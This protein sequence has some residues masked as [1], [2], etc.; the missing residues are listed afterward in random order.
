MSTAPLRSL[1]VIGRSTTGQP[2]TFRVE[3]IADRGSRNAAY[4][5][6][7]AAVVG[8]DVASLALELRTK[9]LGG[10]LQQSRR[11]AA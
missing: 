8:V 11:L 3:T 1:E 10:L 7:A 5:R 2:R 4:R 9:R 6:L